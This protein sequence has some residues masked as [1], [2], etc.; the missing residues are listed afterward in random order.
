MDKKITISLNHLERTVTKL[1]YGLLGYSDARKNDLTV[2]ISLSKED[3]GSGVMTDAITFKT[4]A[5]E[6]EKEPSREQSMIVEIYPMSENQPPRASR[7][8]STSLDKEY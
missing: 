5:P 7:I 2:E 8:D 4:V 6:D 1:R 3:L